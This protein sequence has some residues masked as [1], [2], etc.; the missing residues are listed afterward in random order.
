MT[1]D[2]AATSKSLFR[3]RVRAASGL[4]ADDKLLAGPRLFDRACG[5]AAAG[6]RHRH[7]EADEAAIRAMIDR[8]LA[9]LRRLEGRR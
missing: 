9:V 2:P 4:R 7:P 6:L 3:E 1:M 5:L 8:Q